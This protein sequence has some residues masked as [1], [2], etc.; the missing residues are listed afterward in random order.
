MTCHIISMPQVI[1]ARTVLDR[2]PRPNVRVQKVV[3][4]LV[5]DQSGAIVF[6]ARNEQG[7]GAGVHS[8]IPACG[9]WIMA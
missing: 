4:C 2:A 1:D 3:E 5:A 7:E 6:A 8:Q 9:Q